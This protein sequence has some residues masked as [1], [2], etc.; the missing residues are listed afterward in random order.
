MDKDFFIAML[1]MGKTIVLFDG[2]DEVASESGRTRMS[3]NIQL[4]AQGFPVSPIWVTSRIVGYTVDVKLDEKV[5]NRYYLAQVS[6]DQ[7][8]KFIEK[9]YEIQ[10]PGNKHRREDRIRVL[11]SAVEENAG[12]DIGI[13]LDYIR[14]RT[15]LFIEKGRNKKGQNVFA[16]VHLSFLEYLCA[17][18]VAEDKS[19]DQKAHIK[20]L[21]RYLPK[22]AWEEIILLSLYLFEKSTG[23][24]F[25]DAFCEE[26]F[27]KLRTGHD[28]TS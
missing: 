8:G 9:W 21:V 13:F 15:G 17:Y 1:A 2:L 25:I 19:K 26:V 4:F 14:D 23:P 12:E 20:F 5:F 16:F 28:P 27:K 11:Q 18:Q 3:K 6:P 7:A 24:S 10:I 22:A